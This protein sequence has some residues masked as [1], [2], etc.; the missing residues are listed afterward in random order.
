MALEQLNIRLRQQ[1][2]VLTNEVARRDS[3]ESRSETDVRE[4]DSVD[5]E[6][7]CG[8]CSARDAE[9]DG[10]WMSVDLIYRIRLN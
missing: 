9:P 8:K 7:K 4:L 2:A 1:T 3:Q 10:G 6:S 5:S